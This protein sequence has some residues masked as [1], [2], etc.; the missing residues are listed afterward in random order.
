MPLIRLPYWRFVLWSF[1]LLA[2]IVVGIADAVVLY[3]RAAIEAIVSRALDR[4]V[5]LAE[6]RIVWANQFPCD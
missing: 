5:A 4:R 3:P 2:A 6:L 1:A